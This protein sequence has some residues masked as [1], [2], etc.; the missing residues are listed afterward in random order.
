M[1]MPNLDKSVDLKVLETERLVLEKLTTD[2]AEFILG[3]V[4]EPS[5]VANIGD[6]GVRN[7]DDARRYILDGPVD[8]YQRFGFGLLLTALKFERTPIGVCGLV[9]RETLEGPDLGFAFKPQ[10]WGQGFAYESSAA[11]MK[12]AREVI[13]LKRVLGITSPGNRGSIRILEKVGL[14]FEKLVRLGDDSEQIQLF[15]ADL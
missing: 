14:Q 11:V 4:N 6:R 1:S 5:F 8:S 9:K 3:L 2:D 10:F 7:L 15:A 12:H 13:G